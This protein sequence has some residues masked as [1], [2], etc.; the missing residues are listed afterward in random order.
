MSGIIF[1]ALDASC[2]PINFFF[3]CLITFNLGRW[4]EWVHYC[5]TACSLPF[6]NGG[7][8]KTG[9]VLG[10]SLPAC[11]PYEQGK[12]KERRSKKA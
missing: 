10:A 9:E 1:G 8:G 2:A 12:L 11:M 3:F 6:K 5:T 4:G 7:R